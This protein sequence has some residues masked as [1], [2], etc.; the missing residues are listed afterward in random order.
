MARA[1]AVARRAFVGRW[2]I[3]EMELWTAE[4]LDLQ[5]LA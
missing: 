5:P 1:E 2:R 3:T 4:D